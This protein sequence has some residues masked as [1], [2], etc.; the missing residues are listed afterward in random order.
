MAG[1]GASHASSP[2]NT[3]PTARTRAPLS[4]APTPAR[5]TP[6]QGLTCAVA[7]QQ[8]HLASLAQRLIEAAGAA[9]PPPRGG[10]GGAGDLAALL[11]GLLPRYRTLVGGLLQATASLSLTGAHLRVR[12]RS[13]PA[14]LL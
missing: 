4:P 13:P 14:W 12:P 10:P 1:Q 9:G 11:V 3:T 7:A 2:A 8:Q 5:A 6:P